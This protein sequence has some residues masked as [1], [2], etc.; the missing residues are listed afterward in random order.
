MALYIPNNNGYQLTLIN[1]VHTRRLL[2]HINS[3]SYRRNLISFYPS[4]SIAKTM[5]VQLQA[6][7]PL[8]YLPVPLKTTHLI[9]LSI[10]QNRGQ[11]FIFILFSFFFP[12]FLNSGIHITQ[13]IVK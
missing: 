9:S 12:F 4:Y 8:S 13:I 1:G 3:C 5:N 2:N 10:Q 6:S 7:P 11:I